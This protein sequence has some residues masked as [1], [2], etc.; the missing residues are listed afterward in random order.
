MESKSFLASKT[1]W[2]NFIAIVAIVANSLWGIELDAEVQAALA[3]SILA[4]VNIVLRFTT[5]KAIN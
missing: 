4:I 2:V 1:I 3:T 5:N